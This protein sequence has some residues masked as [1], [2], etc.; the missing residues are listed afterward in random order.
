MRKN[1]FSRRPYL[2]KYQIDMV[3]L[4]GKAFQIFVTGNQ[5]ETDTPANILNPCEA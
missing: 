1:K 4:K 3:F 5:N 2:F